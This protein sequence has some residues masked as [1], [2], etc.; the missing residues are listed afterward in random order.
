MVYE[1]GINPIKFERGSLAMPRSAGFD[2]GGVQIFIDHIPTPHLDGQYTVFGQVI[3]GFS[4]L[5]EIE[6]GDK[7]INAGAVLVGS[8]SSD[9]IGS[10]CRVSANS[11]GVSSG[12][13]SY[14]SGSTDTT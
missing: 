5:D 9:S 4:V 3:E 1:N 6:L 10:D 12:S 7:I 14:S 13:V 11:A 8:V 2:T